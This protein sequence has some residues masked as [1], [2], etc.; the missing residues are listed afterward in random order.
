ML[1]ADTDHLAFGVVR[2]LTVGRVRPRGEFSVGTQYFGTGV[3]HGFSGL[4]TADNRCDDHN[5]AVLNPTSAERHLSPVVED[6]GTGPELVHTLEPDAES[7]RARGAHADHFR[8]D[9]F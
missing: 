1:F 2:D 5:G 4:R 7:C 3:D 8:G 9:P 6:V